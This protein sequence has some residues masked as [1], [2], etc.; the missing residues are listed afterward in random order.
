MTTAQETDYGFFAQPQNR[1]EKSKP[2]AATIPTFPQES[3]PVVNDKPIGALLLKTGYMVVGEATLENNVYNVT[4]AKGKP[5]I[6]AYKVEYAGEDRFDIYRH[7]RD[8]PETAS[9]D[10]TFALAKWCSVNAMYDEAITEFQNCKSYVSYLPQIKLLDKEIATVEQM[11]INAEKRLNAELAVVGSVASTEHGGVET[12]DD[13]FDYRSWGLVVEPKVLE[14]FKKD[15]QPQLLKRCAAADCH[16]SN[17]PQEF[18]L[19][20]PLQKYSTAE[21]TMRNLKATFD[22]LDFQQPTASPLFVNPQKEH[23]GT[24]AIYT[25]QT[26]SQLTPIFQWAQLVPNTMPDFVDKYLAQKQEKTSAPKP[27][28]VQA[29]YS[30]VRQPLEYDPIEQASHEQP[31]VVNTD[32]SFFNRDKPVEQKIELA[33]NENRFRTPIAAPVKIDAP[34]KPV[35]AKDPFDP[36]LFNEKYPR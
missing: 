31:T 21:A 32:F 2:I 1:S 17:S 19:N 14:K 28:M 34:R 33:P 3:S 30:E 12:Q 11:K 8:K 15:V 29:K 7:K 13:S 5:R 24:K 4:G 20:V 9:Y 35:Q 16:G 23:G 10:G 25:R 27:A 26:K 36:S 18:R 6:P 22:Q